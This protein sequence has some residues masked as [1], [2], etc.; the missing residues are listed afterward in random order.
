MSQTAVFGHFAH[1]NE[2]VTAP[3][4]THDEGSG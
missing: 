3:I 1:R 2:I 4:R